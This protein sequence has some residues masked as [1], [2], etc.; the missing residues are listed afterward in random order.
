MM[1]SMME[2]RCGLCCSQCTYREA[3]GCPGCIQA[4]QPFWGTCPLKT[5]AEGKRLNHCGECGAFPCGIL[6]DFAYDKEHG[7]GD[8]SRIE[9]CRRW[10]A[11]TGL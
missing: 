1:E 2:S 10:A 4:A 7:E 8:G 9:R 5:C 3:A 6:L 11:R